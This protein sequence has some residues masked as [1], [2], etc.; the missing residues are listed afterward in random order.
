MMVDERSGNGLS[1]EPSARLGAGEAADGLPP[2]LG[3]CR[4]QHRLGAG[5]QAV[6]Y[7]AELVED[8]PYGAAGSTVAVKVLRPERSAVGNEMRRFRQ[9]AELGLGLRHPRVV[10]THE[11]AEDEVEGRRYVFLVLEYVEG[12]TLRAVMDQLGVVPEALL[13]GLA[14]QIASA[15]DALHRAGAVHRDLK[16]TN[17]LITSDYRVKLM[18]LGVAYRMDATR[19][20]G[21][22]R[23]I[24]TLDYIAPEQILG[25]TA[26]PATDLYSLGIIL[27][28][29]TTGELP[30]STADVRASLGR[31]LS[32]TLPKV[33]QLNPG[34]T[35]FIEEVVATLMESEPEQRFRSAR[36]LATLLEE[37]E[38]GQWWRRREHALRARAGRP[39]RRVKVP[40][41]TPFLGRRG[42]LATLQRW[43]DAAERGEGGL[44][45][46]GG[47]AGIGKSR[48]VDELLASLE[49]QGR[50]VHLLL[51]THSPGVG[52]RGSLGEAVVQL[53]GDADLED[54]LARRM[55]A[56]QRL[57]PGF[58]AL[59]RGVPEAAA[60]PLSQEAVPVLFGRLLSAL[61]EERPVLWV[62]EDLHFASA[63]SRALVAALARAAE[64]RP[65]LV[66]VTARTAEGLD[67]SPPRRLD[68]DRL[69]EDDVLEIARRVLGSGPRQR[70][71]ALAI[72]EKAD[73][74]PFFV[75]EIVRGLS[76]EGAEER[77]RTLVDGATE[78]A[79]EPQDPAREAGVAGPA[80]QRSLVH[81][82]PSSVRDLLASRI[83]DLSA[84]DRSLLDVAAVQG[85]H[86]D[87][88]L[89]ARVCD[90]RPLGVLERL[91]DLERRHGVVRATG[92]G[93][94]FDH[95]L[96]Q[97]LLYEGLA[98]ALRREY[99]ARLAAAA[100][101]RAAEGGGAADEPGELAVFL[102]HHFLRAGD[103]K[104]G[105]RYVLPAIDHLAAG[106]ETERLLEL[107]DTAL[108]L[109]A[110]DPALSC[111]LQ[112]RRADCLSLLGRREEEQAAAEV[113]REAARRAD[114]PVRGA[115]ARLAEG[116]V[117]VDT[118]AGALPV[119]EDALAR[120]RAC[121]EHRA[122][123]A[124]L[125]LLGHLHV[126]GGDFEQARRRYARQAEI[127]SAAGDAAGA[128]EAG[129]YLGETLLA[130]GRCDEAR[131]RLEVSVEALRELGA[132]R[133][134]ARATA[135]LALAWF[136]LGDLGRADRLYAS[137]IT[138]SRE[139][140]F[141]EG[142]V[143][144]LG[145][146]TL[147]ALTE[148]DVEKASDLISVWVD[149]TLA[150]GSPFHDAY[151]LLYRG[152]YELLRGR[153]DA[154]GALYRRALDAFRALE[155]WYGVAEAALALVRLEIERGDG[156][157]LDPERSGA[158]L[159]E[160]ESL[161]E[162][163]SMHSLHPLPTAYRALLGEV[164]PATVPHGAAAVHCE[165]ELRLVL[166]RAGGEEEHLR[167][168]LELLAT[169]SQHLD[170]AGVQRFWRH[171]RLARRAR[172]AAGLAVEELME[173]T[174]ELPRGPTPERPTD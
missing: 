46:V 69:G 18:D 78:G 152:D 8:R 174:L 70:T 35:P 106:F 129:Y 163:H 40:R 27:H 84:A 111:D 82:L 54:E 9:E 102:A 93:F 44:A 10:R 153:E 120:A 126:R 19:L 171:N 72:A 1:S 89:L 32:G 74:N 173:A 58:A 88:A 87:P 140:G 149:R 92:A 98:P 43:L 116:R 103:R 61:A 100:A 64:D 158:L 117:L 150:L 31:R 68:L 45:L 148:G 172:R 142:E 151:N 50:Q 59:L 108:A 81:L 132:S 127:A 12:R 165:A 34:L 104:Q 145:N 65:A 22:G 15:L 114:D 13:R 133:V 16:P 21:T 6:V 156:G 29:A 101:A 166:H 51:S 39:A 36:E 41:D 157:R 160:A 49:A 26:T 123:A 99:H 2:L 67:L 130:L 169:L 164:D 138:L 131:E 124:A 146:R 86:F 125:G 76:E 37:G 57:I 168:A 121:G 75:T 53:L 167:R 161:V 23:F 20:T 105:G 62:V 60:E 11:L 97:E 159:R 66:L 17:V 33:G 135:D 91:S 141:L 7:Q 134:E 170:G 3:P 55:P 136:M 94:E 128:A 154:A 90:E 42:E 14:A 95:H 73:G 139:I 71:L 28:E 113:A 30:F 122:E 155:G 143:L 52:R 119:L 25:E 56:V 144:A 162:T 4:L 85:S 137:S 24:G 115:H 112:L 107:A 83:S 110:D 109:L 63:D 118:G 38:A 96:L 48:L 80:R 79:T 5:G 147:L 77:A 47:E